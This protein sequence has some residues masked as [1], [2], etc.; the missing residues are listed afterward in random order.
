MKKYTKLVF[1]LVIISLLGFGFWNLKLRDQKA[2]VQ[3]GKVQQITASLKISDGINIKSFDVSGFIG[4]TALE[5]TQANTK[6]VTTG[7]GVNA[8]VTSIDGRAAD[9][10]E[11]E[12]WELIANGDQTQVGA[13]SY[14][15]QNGDKIEW[16]ISTY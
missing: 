2:T 7:T 14:I 1:L 4:K 3:N 15:I 11:R 12:F 6:V 16:K 13:G 5:A 9:T 8:F 10:K